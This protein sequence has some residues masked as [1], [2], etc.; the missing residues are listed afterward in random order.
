M[1]R[2]LQEMKE[3]LDSQPDELPRKRL[4]E[5]RGFL[6]YVTQTYNAMQ[7]ND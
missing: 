5:I 6:N 4:E 1:K 7:L 3:L 2:L